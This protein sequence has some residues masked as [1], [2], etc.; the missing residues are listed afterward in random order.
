MICTQN[1]LGHFL[2]VQQALKMSRFSQLILYRG[3]IFHNN[4][5]VYVG[6]E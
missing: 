2:V 6:W 5:T 1:I 4:N 3:G